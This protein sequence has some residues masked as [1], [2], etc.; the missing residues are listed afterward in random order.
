[1]NARKHQHDT[2]ATFEAG[3]PARDYIA[4][5]SVW[6]KYSPATRSD[7]AEYPEA[8]LCCVEIDEGGGGVVSEADYERL[9]IEQALLDEEL[10][11]QA[12]QNMEG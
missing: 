5:Y 6:G 3:D 10:A 8:E 7:P 4:W 9:G 11:I 2:Y 12:L 1:V